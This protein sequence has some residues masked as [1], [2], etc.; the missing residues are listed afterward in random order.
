MHLVEE[1]EVGIDI[2]E[3]VDVGPSPLG[4]RRF[5]ENAGGRIEGDRVHAT[6]RAGA[7]DWLIEG[8]DGYAR[9]D[10][11]WTAETDDGAVLYAQADGLIELN[12]AAQAA[13]AGGAGTDYGDQYIRVVFRLET[14]DPR[15]AWVNTNV[16]IGQGRLGPGPQITYRVNR[17]A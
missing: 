11:R 2:S 7:G 6:L 8:P 5:V 3:V 13:I 10:I 15:Y 12:E 4:R 9:A 17:V 16:F 1:F 14:G